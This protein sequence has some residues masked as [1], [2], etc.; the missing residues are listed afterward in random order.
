[1]S[2]QMPGASLRV[3]PRQT[4]HFDD[5]AP[6]V[7][8]L[9][10]PDPA[11]PRQSSSPGNAALHR[12]LS[13]LRSQALL[14]QEEQENLGLGSGYLAFSLVK[15][16]WDAWSLRVNDIAHEFTDL[17]TG[18]CFFN[19]V[20][21]ARVLHGWRRFAEVA[22]AR[23][24]AFA[25]LLES[26]LR[27]WRRVASSR[28]PLLAEAIWMRD[29]NALRFGFE[30]WMVISATASAV[31]DLVDIDK[32]LEL[33]VNPADRREKLAICLLFSGGEVLIPRKRLV[34]STVGSRLLVAFQRRGHVA[35]SRMRPTPKASLETPSV[36]SR[37][38]ALNKLKELRFAGRAAV[39][40]AAARAKEAKELVDKTR[41]QDSSDPLS[42]L[43]SEALGGIPVS[44]QNAPPSRAVDDGAEKELADMLELIEKAKTA[45]AELGATPRPLEEADNS[46]T[47]I[48]RSMAPVEQPVV[49]LTG[50][51]CSSTRHDIDPEH[52]D[53]QLPPG[54]APDFAKLV[55]ESS[56][57]TADDAFT[58]L[59]S[60]LMSALARIATL[61]DGLSQPSSSSSA[62]SLSRD[63]PE[64]VKQVDSKVTVFETQHQTSRDLFS[65]CLRPECHRKLPP[66]AERCSCMAPAS[67]MDLRCDE[68]GR[69]DSNPLEVVFGALECPHCFSP[70]IYN[71]PDP[72][73]RM[74][75]KKKADQAKALQKWSDPPTSVAHALSKLTKPTRVDND[76][77]MLV[78]D[79]NDPAN[80]QIAPGAADVH[81]I[82]LMME[83]ACVGLPGHK[84]FP[85]PV[86][87]E[88]SAKILLATL[89][90][91]AWGV[92]QSDDGTF[93]CGPDDFHEV[94][95][96]HA[97]IEVCVWSKRI[98]EAVMPTQAWGAPNAK[99]RLRWALDCLTVVFRH[100]LSHKFALE[101]AELVEVLFAA[102][103]ADAVPAV[104]YD[105]G[106]IYKMHRMSIAWWRK[107]MQAHVTKQNMSNFQS[108]LL[109]VNE[110][111][112]IMRPM[113]VARWFRRGETAATWASHLQQALFAP[114]DQAAKR[115][116]RDLAD[117]E[118]AEVAKREKARAA[119]QSPA[120]NPNGGEAGQQ[121]S[122]GA[123]RLAK[124]TGPD[125]L[126]EQLPPPRPKNGERRSKPV[127]GPAPT[128]QAFASKNERAA[129][130]SR[131]M[132]P[133]A[134]PGLPW[135]SIAMADEDSP[136]ESTFCVNCLEKGHIAKN[137]TGERHELAYTNRGG[138]PLWSIAQ[139]EKAIT[140]KTLGVAAHYRA[141]LIAM[142]E[143]AVTKTA[144]A[145]S[146]PEPC[147]NAPPVVPR[148]EA[149]LADWMQGVASPL[150]MSQL[151]LEELQATVEISQRREEQNLNKF[152]AFPLRATR[153][154][155]VSAPSRSCPGERHDLSA[156]AKCFSGNLPTEV[157]VQT[158]RCPFISVAQAAGED[159]TQ[160]FADAV[161]D[162]KRVIEHKDKVFDAYE[163][164]ANAVI[165]DA[166][167]SR[168][169]DALESIVCPDQ[170]STA[171]WM[172]T[173]WPELLADRGV[174]LVFDV[175]GMPH[176]QLYLPASP[177]GHRA[178]LD[179]EVVHVLS[180]QNHMYA[181][182]WECGMET[183]REVLVFLGGLHRFADVG[184]HLCLNVEDTL[185]A[186]LP[187]DLPFLKG[188][189]ML[190]NDLDANR[191]S[192]DPV[193][194]AEEEL[195]EPPCS[196]GDFAS[197]VADS[198]ASWQGFGAPTGHAVL[199]IV[200]QC[201]ASLYE[202]VAPYSSAGSN[203]ANKLFGAGFDPLTHAV[204]RWPVLGHQAA[205]NVL[206]HLQE[207]CQVDP[208][209]FTPDLAIAPLRAELSRIVDAA[210]WQQAMSNAT[211][212][213]RLLSC[214]SPELAKL[215]APMRWKIGRVQRAWSMRLT[216]SLCFTMHASVR[217]FKRLIDS[218]EYLSN[219]VHRSADH[220]SVLG[221]PEVHFERVVGPMWAR[222]AARARKQALFITV[223]PALEGAVEAVLRVTARWER[224]GFRLGVRTVHDSRYLFVRL[225]RSRQARAEAAAVAVLEAQLPVSSPPLEPEP[226]HSPIA[227]HQ[228]DASAEPLV[229]YAQARERRANPP[230]IG[231]EEHYSWQARMFASR[232]RER[233]ARSMRTRVGPDRFRPNLDSSLSDTDHSSSVSDEEYRRAVGLRVSS[234]GHPSSGRSELNTTG[235][236][237]LT[238]P[239][240]SLE[241]FSAGS[242]ERGLKPSVAATFMNAL[243]T[244]YRLPE[245]RAV[246]QSGRKKTVQSKLSWSPRQAAAI[247]ARL[248]NT[249]PSSARSLVGAAP[250]SVS[251]E[252]PDFPKAGGLGSLEQAP[253][254]TNMYM[255]DEEEPRWRP[256]VLLGRTPEGALVEFR[257]RRQLVNEEFLVPFDADHSDEL[258][259]CCELPI[260]AAGHGLEGE[261]WRT[262]GGQGEDEPEPEA[263]VG[264]SVRHW[265]SFCRRF[266]CPVHLRCGS[267]ELDQAAAAQAELFMLYELAAFDIKAST[268]VEKLWEVGKEHEARQLPNPFED[269]AIVKAVV[270]RVCSLEEPPQPTI[271]VTDSADFRLGAKPTGPR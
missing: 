222:F 150:D 73:E 224:V 179:S 184:L 208:T 103:A 2:A 93:C 138:H 66:G 11:E 37:T 209:S 270:R 81:Q 197:Q 50:T 257:D 217:S 221:W 109:W 77:V 26:T 262:D 165:V 36:A 219:E 245:S 256:C 186:R 35:A 206:A 261:Q 194:G 164:L 115:Q 97:A 18:R 99:L 19:A 58:R 15:H 100:V 56:N 129:I 28:H 60:S 153:S 120:N 137:C 61:E 131:T 49:G 45:A 195:E 236:G 254:W 265:R 27:F 188:A 171:F 180:E 232:N 264:M 21:A 127:Y 210:G 121:A 173:V 104:D 7:V 196:D 124:P 88:V 41:R 158:N 13:T 130:A 38:P 78:R 183:V 198:V 172:R 48:R 162:S 156:T 154:V 140:Q 29:S 119:G 136:P 244:E 91:V 132:W 212:G 269:N 235:E 52:R 5:I 125:E 175:D 51:Q 123:N 268:V 177:S 144:A 207:I 151:D 149:K 182:E 168:A 12:A 157:G 42:Q 229:R 20:A 16:A 263:Q 105:V 240:P 181:L 122:A 152:T 68:C 234:R 14:E 67:I 113:L 233:G 95:S 59:Q 75:W 271:P 242:A 251:R 147:G 54:T 146:G 247:G 4:T 226:E 126:P 231:V 190:I 10:D 134:S 8:A 84:L 65:E 213:A 70:K 178:S 24:K 169:L 248:A 255:S 211:R 118:A 227:A 238:T 133:G 145:E 111:T 114:R 107:A 241:P 253:R 166:F 101:H 160:L 185:E 80:P 193:N 25:H 174:L 92:H 40:D 89:K 64:F 87:F 259:W 128:P 82:I 204:E 225:M 69:F 141:G 108:D 57:T 32:I 39:S 46:H 116:A 220:A 228:V 223:A 260:P 17:N 23:K 53:C 55:A 200:A 215:L 106:Q 187:V 148:Q 252:D 94:S 167:E 34:G 98:L 102:H 230:M 6:R 47:A 139:V 267:L 199:Q 90:G 3:N 202:V 74:K 83:Q 161:R 86:D 33:Q 249:P 258:T 243:P 266:N 79:E 31:P 246:A 1:M 9:P 159:P 163:L 218:A 30:A 85:V 76:I 72:Y 96:N 216:S 62:G 205:Y 214:T 189:E 110:G 201:E 44:P 192:L 71:M 143:A 237:V 135:V 203:I 43:M 176:F 117:K 155:R 250:E 239:E 22:R 112:P 142:R 170:P 191:L 63:P